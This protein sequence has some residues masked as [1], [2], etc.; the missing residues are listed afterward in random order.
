MKR[1]INKH[2]TNPVSPRIEIHD[3]GEEELLV[4]SDNEELNF[5]DKY[6]HTQTRYQGFF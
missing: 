6:N 5:K 3:V 2:K 1:S 4:D